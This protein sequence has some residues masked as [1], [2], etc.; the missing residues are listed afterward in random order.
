MQPVILS[1]RKNGYV[2]TIHPV[3]TDF[4]YLIVNLKFN[5]EDYFLDAT[6]KNLAFGELPFRCLNRYGRLLDF[7]NES[8]WI[9]LKPSKR[10]SMYFKDH[11]VINKDLS[12]T[13][14]SKYVFTGYNALDMRNKLSQSNELEFTKQWKKNN[15][16]LQIENIEIN[17]I[18]NPSK[19]LEIKLKSTDRL[20]EITDIIF[21]KPFLS[22]FFKEN[23]FKLNQRTYPVDFGYCNHYNYVTSINIP[24]NYIFTEIPDSKSFALP[25][26][27][28]FITIKFQVENDKM[29][30]SHR[31]SINSEYFSPDYYGALKEFYSK[32]VEIENDTTITIEKKS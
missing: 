22:P 28:G 20:D 15:P 29:I 27:L 11:L 14:E 21:L 16:E 9:D 3:I 8:K 26:K 13:K 31:V 30:V 17:N 7:N 19:P 4:N 18:D 12:I 1:T 10:T 32:I 23:P 2:T 6:G 24:E 5:D 25:D